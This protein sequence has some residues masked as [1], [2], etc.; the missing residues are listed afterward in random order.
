MNKAASVLNLKN[1][2]F[3]N[4]HGLMNKKAFSCA[5][6]VAKLTYLAM[7]NNEFRKIVSTK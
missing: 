4:A 2:K 3:A 6:D 7:K 5:Y 1:T